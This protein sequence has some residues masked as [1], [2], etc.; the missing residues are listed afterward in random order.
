MI[1]SILSFTLL[2]VLFIVIVGMST[3]AILFMKELLEDKE[4][5]SALGIFLLFL[6][7]ILVCIEILLELI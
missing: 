4:Y 6:M 3:F 1:E 2:T 7:W 5:M